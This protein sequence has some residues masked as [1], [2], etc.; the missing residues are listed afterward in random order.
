MKI[1]QLLCDPRGMISR[2]SFALAAIF[3]VAIKITGDL[4]LARLLFHR[5]WRLRE[6]LFPHLAFLFDNLPDGWKCE[7]ALLL[8]A[9]QFAW[10]GLSLLVQ[11]RRSAR[12]PIPM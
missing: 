8:W 11:G 9:A 6:Y 4:A 7:G 5:T 10:I 12:G 2:L 1:W 3:L